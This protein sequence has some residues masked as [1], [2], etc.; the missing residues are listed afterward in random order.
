MGPRAAHHRGR[1]PVRRRRLRRPRARP[2]PRPSDHRARPGRQAADGP[3]DGPGRARHRRRGGLPR[4]TA[5][6]SAARSACVGFCAGGSLALW[7]ATLSERIVATVGFYPVAALGADA[8]AVGA[9]TPARSA[10]DPL[11]RGR[12]HL[13]RAAASRPARQAIEAAGG[14]CRAP[15]LPGHAARVLQRRPARGLRQPSAAQRLGPHDRASSA[16]LWRDA[17]RTPARGR[18]PRRGGPDLAELDAGGGRLLRLPAAGRLAGGGRRRPSGPPS[19]TRTTGAARCPASAR[20]DARIAI[21]GLAPAAHGGNRTGRIFTGDRSGDV[22]FAALHRAGLANQPTSV[23]RRR[24]PGAAATPGSSRRC[25][26]PR[27]TT[28]RPR[29]SGTP[30]RPGC[31]ASSR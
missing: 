31:T 19:A 14:T 7:S 20:A 3:G 2:L 17:P 1:R 22:L 5:P 15:R 8:S 16:T 9:T 26:A 29:S 10:L 11:L 27:R 6:R 25:A 30:A 21:L 24:R 18:R 12:R 13:G 4:R 23:V 28:S